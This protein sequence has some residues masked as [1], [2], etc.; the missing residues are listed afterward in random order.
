[1][2]YRAQPDEEALKVLDDESD[3]ETNYYIKNSL[4]TRNAYQQK[5]P[6]E[7]FEKL[8]EGINKMKLIGTASTK[9][10][11]RRMKKQLMERKK[12]NL[13]HRLADFASTLVK[14]Q[15]LSEGE[16]NLNKMIMN[17]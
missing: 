8:Q 7:Y 6:M 16:K 11:K 9:L 13:E 12:L 10:Q 5:D 17:D 3:G 2:F 1:M 15:Y 4:Y 14:P